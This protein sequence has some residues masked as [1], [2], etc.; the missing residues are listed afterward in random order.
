MSFAGFDDRD[1]AVQSLLS[2]GYDRDAAEAIADALESE[3]NAENGDA[4]QLLESIKNAGGMILDAAIDL[5][6]AVDVPAIDSKWVMFKSASDDAPG[7][8]NRK[9][10]TEIVLKEDTEGEKRI[11][12][13]PAMIPREPDKEGEVV[14]TPVVENSAHGYLKNGGGVDTD[15]NLIDGKGEV[16]E[17]WILNEAKEY[18][19]PD[20][21]TETYPEGTW[22]LGIEWQA[23]PW[24]RIQNGELTGL[25]IYGTAEHVTLKSATPAHCPDCGAK[26]DLTTEKSSTTED[27]SIDGT[28]KA[29]SSESGEQEDTM[30]DNS[31]SDGAESTPDDGGDGAEDGPTIET[32]ADTLGDI[33][34]RLS[35]VESSL[36]SGSD[37]GSESA[38]AEKDS[39]PAAELAAEY[40]D[41]TKSDILEAIENVAK[42]DDDDDDEEEEGDDDTEKSVSEEE[43]AKHKGSN[44]EGVRKQATVEKQEGSGI[45][46]PSFQE[47]AENTV[48][49]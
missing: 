9:I 14:P 6:S 5:N 41:L 49:E 30:P 15:H 2:D 32:V 39:D 31:G 35:E 24:E 18:E 43:T 29:E 37:G 44:G 26:V 8:Y 17:S 21:G 7:E 4:D 48:N 13:A 38:E 46:R 45:S 19:L 1:D 3:A 47:I 12:F 33:D 20:G 22:M 36:E 11:S 16:V 34:S 10:D 42:E 28:T 40:D 25:S 23:E 27:S